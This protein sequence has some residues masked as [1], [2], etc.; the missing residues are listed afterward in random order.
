MKELK[1]LIKEAGL[2]ATPQRL[3]IYNSIKQKGHASADVIIEDLNATFPSLTIA[4]VYNVLDSFVD[5]GLLER[6]MS[7]NNKM[8]FDVNTYNHAHIY[9]E[10]T[11][12]YTDYND[13]N[14][15]TLVEDYIKRNFNQAAKLKRV[16]IQ[17]ITTDVI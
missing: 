13:P 16:D 3:A 15:I 9:N 8:Y 14:L 12:S 1:Q 7:L 5:V 6:R 11:N 2:K 17:L 4:T 10:T